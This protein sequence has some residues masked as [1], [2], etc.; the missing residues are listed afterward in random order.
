[1]VRVPINPKMLRWARERAEVSAEELVKR[2]PKYIEWELGNIQPTEKQL[3]KFSNTTHAPFG[4]FFFSEPPKYSFPIS[5]FRTIRDTPIKRP[6]LNL[7]HTVFLCQRRQNWYWEYAIF[8]REDALPFVGSKTIK[9]DIEETSKQISESLGVTLSQRRKIQSWSDSLRYFISRA[10]DIG[11]LVMVSG[12]VGNNTHRILNP[13]EF[14]GFSLSDEFAPLVFING[15]DSK[16]TQILTLI[17]ELAQIWLGESALS[18]VGPADHTAHE[19]ESWCNRVAAEVLVPLSSLTQQY[20]ENKNIHVELSRLARYYKVSTLVVLRRIYDL[21]KIGRTKFWQAYQFELKRVTKYQGSRGEFTKPLVA[22]VG[23]RFGLALVAN[24]LE[25]HTT[26]SEALLLLD[27]KKV[28]TFQTFAN[29]M[30]KEYYSH[31]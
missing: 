10:D 29:H 6:S 2:F 27:V 28:S 19:I 9:C 26:Y 25:G 12:V 31:S 13:D 5:D 22:R 4:Y 16:A 8:E 24:T 30:E 18:N 23:R 20:Q 11:I 7:L 3:E 14:R 21:G 1:M 17:H 15:R